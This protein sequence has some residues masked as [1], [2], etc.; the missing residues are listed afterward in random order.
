MNWS[1]EVYD[2]VTSVMVQRLNAIGIP[3]EKY[4][5][6]RLKRLA[7]LRYP[8]DSI[9]SDFGYSR[10]QYTGIFR[11]ISVAQRSWILFTGRPRLQDSFRMF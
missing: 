8:E 4:E 10:R 2:K 6:T 7:Y 9:G 3:L 1:K 5:H 11:K